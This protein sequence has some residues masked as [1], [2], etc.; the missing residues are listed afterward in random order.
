[1]KRCSETRESTPMKP[2]AITV[3]FMGLGLWACDSLECGPGTH[4]ERDQC[5]ANVRVACGEGTLFRD[6][7]C[8]STATPPDAGADAGPGLVCGPG[9]VEVD[10]VC[11]ALDVGVVEPPETGMPDLGPNVDGGVPG[12]DAAPP[13]P[14]AE[15]PPPACPEALTPGVP[16]ADCGALPP[17]E[18]YCVVGLALDFTTGCALPAG[19][20]MLLIDP[21]L[22]AAGQPLAA[23][24]RGETSVGPGGGFSVVGTG[25]A[26]QL[27]LVIDDEAQLRAPAPGMGTW[28]RSAAGITSTAAEAGRVYT[29]LAFATSQ[30]QQAVWNGI[31]GQPAAFLEGNGFLVGRVFDRD[32]EGRLVPRAGAQVSTVGAS[33]AHTCPDGGQCLRFFDDALTLDAF[34]AVGA[35][36]T[37]ASGAFLLIRGGNGAYRSVFS[38]DDPMGVYATLPGGANIGSGFH[39]PFVPRP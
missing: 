22:A 6:G 1:M 5:V 37:G 29:T 8:V 35:R 18:A 23:Y 36:R 4:R 13:V 9:T 3:L 30:A 11:I 28:T 19:L 15:P 17:G 27:A 33:T 24:T 7:R 16:P 21:A 34:Q 26:Q 39:L 14:D 31:L 32:D 25:A 2:T 20:P 38:V 12:E 10:G